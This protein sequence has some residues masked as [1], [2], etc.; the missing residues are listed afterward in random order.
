MHYIWYSISNQT[1]KT[2]LLLL[3]LLLISSV[4]L[5]QVIANQVDDFE[6]EST[7]TPGI[8]SNWTIGSPTVAA[9]QISN[10][11]N[12][13]PDGAG[14]AFFSYST[15]GNANGGGSRMII[16]SRNA[17]WSGDFVAQGIVAIKMDVR[18]S[19]GDLTLRV[20]LSNQDSNSFPTTQMVTTTPIFITAGTEWQSMTIPISPSDFTIVEASG[21]LTPAQ[22]L[23]SVVEMRILS[24][25]N[26]FWLGEP[27]LRTMDLDN[28]TAVTTLSTADVI[29]NNE[30]S[31]S[32]NPATTRLN[33]YLPKNSNDAI[34][35]VYDVLGKRVFTKN[36]DALTAS[37]DVSKWN[38]GVYLV[39]ISTDNTTQTKRFVKH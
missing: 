37:I 27:G 8:Y 38:S 10:P 29:G 6:N 21:G 15:T 14:D 24:S 7:E 5:S 25:P 35:S 12:G 16:Y 3:S 34:L 2:K 31:I 28:I 30:F 19:S 18:A 33:V 20:G 11:S 17:Q 1:M 22:V 39:R 9:N 13:G 26:P 23:S 32:P 36:I 4:A